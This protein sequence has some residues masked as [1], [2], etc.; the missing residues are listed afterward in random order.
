MLV[1]DV[2]EAKWKGCTSGSAA[3]TLT[4]SPLSHLLPIYALILIAHCDTAL[5]YTMCAPALTSMR[6]RLIPPVHFERSR[7]RWIV[8]TY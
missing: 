7:A 3:D 8:H 2:T 5:Q 1:R 4:K 6:A